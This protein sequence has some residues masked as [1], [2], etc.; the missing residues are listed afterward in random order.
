MHICRRGPEHPDA[1]LANIEGCLRL[2]MADGR[3]GRNAVAAI[4]PPLRLAIVILLIAG[5][6]R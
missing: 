4:A 5:V 3:P 1:H 2:H 6:E